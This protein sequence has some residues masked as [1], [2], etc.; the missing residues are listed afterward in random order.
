[1]ES[2]TYE[3]QKKELRKQQPQQ[4]QQFI[5]FRFLLLLVVSF[6]YTDDFVKL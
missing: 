5:E 1:M 6:S 2:S 3:L 4:Q